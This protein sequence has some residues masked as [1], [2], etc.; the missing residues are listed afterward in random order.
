MADDGD[1]VTRW[2]E[3]ENISLADKQALWTRL[4]LLEQLG[5][6]SA[7]PGCIKPLGNEGG[8]DFYYMDIKAGKRGP[9]LQPVFCYG[10]FAEREITI[11]AG[12]PI[13]NRILGPRDVLPVAVYNLKLL[14]QAK[15]RKVLLHT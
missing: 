15:R 3:R 13:E 6:E 8:Q 2:L 1:V 11:L 10:P 9:P 7:L 14:K 12:A 5:P 4:D